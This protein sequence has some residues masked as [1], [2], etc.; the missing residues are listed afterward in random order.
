MC[1]QVAA[2]CCEACAL[3]STLGGAALTQRWKALLLENPC[4]CCKHSMGNCRPCIHL[5]STPPTMPSEFDT[6]H[7]GLGNGVWY[8]G[9]VGWDSTLRSHSWVKNAH[10]AFLRPDVI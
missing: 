9:M 5:I 3:L 8:L 1:P 7:G 2:C 4:V 6:S 10:R